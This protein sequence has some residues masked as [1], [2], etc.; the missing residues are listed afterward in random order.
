MKAATVM[1]RKKYQGME[2]YLSSPVK[3]PA[4]TNLVL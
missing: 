3:R 4:S 1:I 2:G